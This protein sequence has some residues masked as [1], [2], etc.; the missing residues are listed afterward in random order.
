MNKTYI[1]EL[2]NNNL[3]IWSFDIIGDIFMWYPDW[4]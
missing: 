3:V 1:Y 2:K 4:L